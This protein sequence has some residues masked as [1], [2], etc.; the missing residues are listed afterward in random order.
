[1]II[2]PHVHIGHDT[3]W[4]SNRNEEEV[5]RVMNQVGVTASII[6]PAQF[7]TFED[8]KR[9]HDR[10]YDFSLKHPTRIFGMFS[11]NPHFDEKMYR[12]EARRCVNELG[13]VGIKLTPL[14]HLMNGKVKRARL[15]FEMA[16]ELS[17]PLMIHQGHGMPWSLISS[18]YDLI[19]EFSDITVVFAHSGCMDT[20]DEDI[21]M[22]KMCPNVF[23][24][25]YVRI[26]N[27]HNIVRFVDA[28]GS[29]RVM[30]AS[31]SPDEMA[32]ISW[33]CKHAG[34]SD[35][36]VEDL[37]WRSCAKAYKLEGRVKEE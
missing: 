26:P 31:D 18:Y 36:Q 8:F 25:L 15:P 7:V 32:H 1:M 5:M 17:V 28:I 10:I 4:E 11:C 6:Q 37:L 35:D 33:E 16:R 9:G 24:E 22:A 2:D 30:Y 27:I 20:V 21:I 29:D 14:T 3:T 19:T 13:F 34:L 23:L 12:E